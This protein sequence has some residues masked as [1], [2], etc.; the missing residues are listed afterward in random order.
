MPKIHKPRL[1]APLVALCLFAPVYAQDAAPGGQAAAPAPSQEEH[2]IGGKT[3][4]AEQMADV[5]A[6]CDDLRQGEA[7]SPVAEAA[8]DAPTTAAAT[9]AA[10]GAAIQMSQELWDESGTTLDVE[11]LSLELCDEGNFGLSDAAKAEATK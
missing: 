1:F 8:S 7:Q 3:V 4:T 10:E 6:K 2:R 5:Q 9:D 11:K